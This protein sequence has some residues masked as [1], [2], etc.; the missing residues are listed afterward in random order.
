MSSL[1]ESSDIKSSEEPDGL[2][3]VESTET[4]TPTSTPTSL[5]STPT[6]D[7]QPKKLSEEEQKFISKYGSL[8]KKN[9][10]L[11]NRKGKRFDSA[12]YFKALRA[13]K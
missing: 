1:T 13:S 6:T 5:S 9:S 12:D 8:K 3:S 2:I 10:L 7:E 11:V 4:N